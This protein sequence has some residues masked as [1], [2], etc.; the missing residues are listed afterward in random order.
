MTD[1][2]RRRLL[3]ASAGAAVAGAVAGVGGAYA[4]QAGSGAGD[5]SAVVGSGG[6][7]DAEVAFRGEHQSG[8]IT[9]AQDRMHFVAL[10]V[11]TKDK[12]AVAE[13]LKAWTRA[14]ERMTVGAEAAPGGVVGGGPYRAP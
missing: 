9:P 11:V 10:D 4:A 6:A 7:G 14:A 12:A 2:S 1:L 8:I 5:G 3:G 13:M